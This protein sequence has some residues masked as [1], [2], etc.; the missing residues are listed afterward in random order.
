MLENAPNLYTLA[1]PDEFLPGV[2]VQYEA[3]MAQ[4]RLVMDFPLAE[5]VEPAPVF[6]P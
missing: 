4:A 3:L 1:I 2:M 5:E 6:T